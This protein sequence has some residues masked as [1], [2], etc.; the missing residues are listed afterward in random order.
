VIT[1]A[2]AAT[3]AT[4]D[5]IPRPIPNIPRD[6]TVT[7]DLEEH[8]FKLTVV[9]V[10]RRTAKFATDP[11]VDGCTLAR[12]GGGERLPLMP[13]GAKSFGANIAS[14]KFSKYVKILYS[15][16]SLS[17]ELSLEKTFSHIY[18]KRGSLTTTVSHLMNLRVPELFEA[19][20]TV[21]SLLG[22]VQ[23]QKES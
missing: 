12:D 23:L 8:A 17:P 5:F 15:T 1:A 18:H 20:S 6:A 10:S 14:F 21:V 13:F 3:D 2:A 16:S 4:A 7:T 22:T 11:E 19:Y 9:H